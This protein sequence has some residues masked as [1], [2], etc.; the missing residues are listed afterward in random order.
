MTFHTHDKVFVFERWQW[1]WYT[2]CGIVAN[3]EEE[4]R[5]LLKKHEEEEEEDE[6]EPSTLDTDWVYVEDYPF[7]T[8]KWE[9]IFLESEW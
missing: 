4:G 5:L 3:T 8:K 9:I 2:K 6:Y 7:E 1:G